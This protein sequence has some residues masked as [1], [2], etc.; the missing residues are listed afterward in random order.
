MLM[1]GRKD[2]AMSKIDIIN[3]CTD[4]SNS[5]YRGNY[6]ICSIT[7]E[8]AEEHGIPSSCRLPD[9][10]E[11][12]VEADG[13]TQCDCEK[14]LISEKSYCTVCGRDIYPPAA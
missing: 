8:L 10:T 9:F 13:L 3:Y 14:P 4:C 5:K 1:F 12:G 7:G 6:W 11:P 2:Y